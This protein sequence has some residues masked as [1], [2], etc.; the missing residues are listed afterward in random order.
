MP[1][2]PKKKVKTSKPVTA[3]EAENMFRF[4]ME[5]RNKGG[6]AATAKKFKRAVTT[7][8][9]TAEKNN[10]IKRAE[11]IQDKITRSN[12]QDITKKEL[13]NL[14]AIR[15]IKTYVIESILKR[16]KK[17]DYIPTISEF[18][19]LLRYE[20]DITGGDAVKDNGG[21]GTHYNFIFNNAKPD[22]RQTIQDNVRKALLAKRGINGE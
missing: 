12:D 1:R 22:E 18:I 17:D 4:W 13:K 10:W 20:D 2:K 16:L 11:K 14:D 7:V 19:S 21:G 9:R 6:Y 3:T 5:H 8:R 15:K